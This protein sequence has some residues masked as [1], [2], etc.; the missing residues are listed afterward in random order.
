VNIWIFSHYA[1]SPRTTGGTRHYDMAKHLVKKGHNVTIV[2][3]S[4]NHYSKKEDHFTS[5]KAVLKREVIDGVNFLWVK[6][7]GYTSNNWRRAANML[8]YTYRALFASNKMKESPDL[9]IGSLVHPFAALLG[10]WVARKKKCLFYFEERDLWPQTLIDIWKYSEKHPMIKLFGMIEKFLY[11]KA[12][13]IIVLFEKAVDYVES[14][15]VPRNKVIFIPNGVDLSRVENTSHTMPDSY[16]AIFDALEKKFIAIYTGSHGLTNQ[17]HG[18]LEVAKK[19]DQSDIHFIFIGEG[20]EKFKLVKEANE[21]KLNNIT[22]LDPIS[23][24]QIPAA[25]DK[26]DVGLIALSDSPLYKWGFSLNKIYDY[27][28]SSLPILFLCNTDDPIFRRTDSAVKLQTPEQMAEKLT[29][30][31]NDGEKLKQLSA[32]SIEYVRANHSW[33]ILA[34]KLEQELQQDLNQINM[35]S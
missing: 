20:P 9:V 6:S 13:K 26:A 23:K 33:E 5:E 3:S 4:F 1:V 32:N 12:T 15:G 18:L 24:E 10:Y 35:K 29:E 31:A 34:R 30:L 25:L 22:F 19:V 7:V 2:A 28:A 14:R 16:N 17:L 11:K 8:Q 27:M 21:S